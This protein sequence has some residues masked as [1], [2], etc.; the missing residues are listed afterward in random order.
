MKF[1]EYQ[2]WFALSHWIFVITFYKQ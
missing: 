1:I 2:R